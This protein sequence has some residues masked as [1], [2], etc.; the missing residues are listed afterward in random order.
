MPMRK[1]GKTREHPRVT[2]TKSAFSKTKKKQ[3]K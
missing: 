1:W 2:E 3:K